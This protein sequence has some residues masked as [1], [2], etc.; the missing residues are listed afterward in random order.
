MRVPLRITG[1][2]LAIVAT[3]QACGSYTAPN[4]PP[5]TPDSAGH[6][7]GGSMPSMPSMP[8]YSHM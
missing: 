7:T 3:L 8:G 6:S 5:S 2:V 4:N 1:I